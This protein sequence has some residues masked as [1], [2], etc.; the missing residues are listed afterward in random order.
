MDKNSKIFFTLNYKDLLKANFHIITVPTPI[1]EFNSPDLSLI[2]KACETVGKIIKK[3]DIIY[4]KGHVAAALSRDY[5]IHAY[6]PMK[7][8]VIMKTVNTIKRIDRT[9]KLKVIGVKKI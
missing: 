5:L 2:K 4:W 7:K 8:T 6:G 9:A 3:N 1:D